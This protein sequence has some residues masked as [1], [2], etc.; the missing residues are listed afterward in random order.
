MKYY[1]RFYFLSKFESF[2][3]IKTDQ[4]ITFRLLKP[5]LKIEK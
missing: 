1:N 3:T 4:Q 2:K 5:C